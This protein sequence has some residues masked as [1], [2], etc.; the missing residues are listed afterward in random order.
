MGQSEDVINTDA[1]IIGASNAMSVFDVEDI[2]EC[3]TDVES[4]LNQQYNGHEKWVKENEDLVNSSEAAEDFAVDGYYRFAG[5]LPSLLRASIFTYAYGR[6]EYSLHTLCKLLQAVRHAKCGPEDL[7]DKGFVRSRKYLEKIIG[8]S[9]TAVECEALKTISIY[10]TLRNAI[11][12]N[13]GILRP[14]AN[15]VKDA[16]EY[17]RQAKGMQLNDERLLRLEST[18]VF[19][20]ML[21][22]K[23]VWTFMHERSAQVVAGDGVGSAAALP[24]KRKT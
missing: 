3:L 12:H 24:E 7:K 5:S 9:W 14:D 23:N 19:E 11:V 20:A 10:G 1:E 22:M 18:F 6:L 2:L 17:I 16:E 8:I 4:Y 13:S 15:G 21:H